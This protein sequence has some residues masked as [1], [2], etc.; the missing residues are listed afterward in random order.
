MPKRYLEMPEIYLSV[1]LIKQFSH[2]QIIDMIEVIRYCK[3]TYLV[4]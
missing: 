2:A 4:L 3:E 1:I